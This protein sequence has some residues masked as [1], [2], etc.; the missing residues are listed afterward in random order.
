MLILNI[1]I[2]A[3]VMFALGYFVGK[4][5]I[6]IKRVANKKMSEEMLKQEKEELRTQI[7][8]MNE[9]ISEYNQLAKNF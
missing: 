6:E 2:L 5:K 8:A 9:A 4:G 7:I 1:I 3:V